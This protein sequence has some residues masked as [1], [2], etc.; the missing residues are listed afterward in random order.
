[1]TTYW[2][3][4]AWLGSTVVDAGVEIE[5][6]AGIIAAIRTGVTT[7]ADQARRLAGVTLP[8]FANAH[9]HA[10]HRVLR[11]RTHEAGRGS[12]WT[13]RDQMYDIA[14]RLTPDNYHRLARAAY[15][16]MAMA[17]ITAVGEFHYVHHQAG[18]TPYD[19]ENAMAEALLA[20]ADAAGIRLT[21]L[22]TCYLHGGLRGG[23]PVAL[24]GVQRRF[25]DGTVERWAERAGELGNGER[26]RIGAAVHS[27]RAVSPAAIDL[28]ADWAEG[29]GAPLH[30]HVS[31]QPAENDACLAAHGRT[32]VEVF[33]SA[34][35]PLFTA[36]HA[37]HL[38][39]SDRTRLGATASTCCLCPTTER[40][41]AD[42]V[43]RAAD[44]RAEGARLALGSD[45]HA[46]IDMFE[47]ARA[48][49]LNERLVS[50]ERGRHTPAELAAMATEAGHAALGWPD[51]GRITIGATA[52]LT[53]VG[54]DSVRLSGTAPEHVLAAAI[55]AATAADVT[56]VVVGGDVIVADGQHLTLDVAGELRASIDE[57]LDV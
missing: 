23:G 27:V 55:F 44:L 6:E 4:L 9:S 14:A 26:V 36:V 29:R 24:D 7:P 57:V 45:S 28:I 12:F 53:T 8:G 38:T 34:L 25:G 46:M 43:A 35:G 13:W 41:L 15:G 37:T 42:G 10:F 17:G 11:G 3:E 48:V 47:E 5:I 32:P 16:E 54:L 49:E 31:E 39:A 1:V 50:G 52:D 56:H 30:A 2:C 22:D 51:S 21:L 20:A 33:E 40:D 18:G 19:D